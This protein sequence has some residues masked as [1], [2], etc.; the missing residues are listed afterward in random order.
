[1]CEHRILELERKYNALRG[2]LKRI[3]HLDNQVSL[4]GKAIARIE[5]KLNPQPPAKMEVKYGLPEDCPVCCGCENQCM[6]CPVTDK[7]PM[8]NDS[9]SDICLNCECSEICD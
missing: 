4:L 2:E 3:S 7:C 8:Y 6:G 5:S 9:R 1:M